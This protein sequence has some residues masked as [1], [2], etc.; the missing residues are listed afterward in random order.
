MIIHQSC[1]PGEIYPF[2]MKYNIINNIKDVEHFYFKSIEDIV[3]RTTNGQSTNV[4]T[5]I[6]LTERT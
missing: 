5:E 4:S 3:V 2:L 6:S 1:N